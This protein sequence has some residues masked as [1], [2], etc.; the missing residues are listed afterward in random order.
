MLP[1]RTVILGNAGS[2][3][4]TLARVLGERLSCSVVHLDRLFWRPKWKEPEPMD[5]RRRVANAISGPE[6]ICEGNYSR[7]TFDLR[8]P[9]ADLVIWMDTPRATCLR[10]VVVRNLLRRPRPDMPVGCSERLNKEFI[11]FLRFVWTFD[12]DY[13]PKIENE[14]LRLGAHVPVVRLSSKSQIHSFLTALQP[15]PSADGSKCLSRK[16]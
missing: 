4:S 11:T 7:R 8:L 2:G 1:R 13:R 3:K 16:S 15:I 6:W 5:F 12:R 14:R 9:R 10:R